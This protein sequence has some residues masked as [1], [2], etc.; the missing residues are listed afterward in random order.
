[1]SLAK[2]SL[3]AYRSSTTEIPGHR[4]MLFFILLDLNALGESSLQNFETA[5]RNSFSKPQL[6][7][8]ATE[9]IF[10]FFPKIKSK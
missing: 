6:I 7:C 9:Q 5:E 4:L 3:I 1:M 10:D 8:L 2:A